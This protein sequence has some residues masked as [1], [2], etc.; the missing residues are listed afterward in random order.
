M[1]VCDLP[2]FCTAALLLMLSHFFLLFNFSIYDFHLIPP[3][4][5]PHSPFQTM[6]LFVVTFVDGGQPSIFKKLLPAM[7]LRKL[8]NDLGSQA[9]GKAFAFSSD[10]GYAQVPPEDEGMMAVDDIALPGPNANSNAKIFMIK[11]SFETKSAQISRQSSNL[12]TLSEGSSQTPHSPSGPTVINVHVNPSFN[13]SPVQKVLNDNSQL[14]LKKAGAK[15][16]GKSNT[17]SSTLLPSP[18]TLSAKRGQLIFVGGGGPSKKPPYLLKDGKTLNLIDVDSQED[19][20]KPFGTI[21]RLIITLC[22]L[23]YLLFQRIS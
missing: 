8:R 21:N 14:V 18:P 4:L 11:S 22:P 5:C 23:I 3:R 15:E 7:S 6:K 17:P 20:Y 12:S 19:G 1:A 9:D 13:N 10:A 2:P 16:T